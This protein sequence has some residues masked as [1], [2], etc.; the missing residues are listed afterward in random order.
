M[1]AGIGEHGCGGNEQIKRMEL[2]VWKLE[3]KTTPPVT[4]A[5]G[6]LDELD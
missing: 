6:R 5:G 4:V 1:V 2:K 3:R